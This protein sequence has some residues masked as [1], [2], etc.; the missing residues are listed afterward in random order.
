MKLAKSGDEL[1]N[2][3]Y[4]SA[5]QLQTLFD[6]GKRNEL[7]CPACLEQVKLYLGIHEPPYFYHQR[8]TNPCPGAVAEAKSVPKI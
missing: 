2:L 5:S 6:Q 3:Q 7:I 4:I 8:T 1:I